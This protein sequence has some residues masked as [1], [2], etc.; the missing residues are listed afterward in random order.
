M[1]DRN[2][3]ETLRYLGYGRND[4][5]RQ[6]LTMAGECWSELERTAAKR[7]CFREYPLKFLDDGIMDLG[8]FQ[9]ES[10]SLS[11]NLKDCQ[12]VILFAATLGV[13][14]DSLIRKYSRLQMSRAVVLQAAAAAM[15]E[16]YCDQV[17]EQLR[18]DY[19]KK[20][21]YLRPRFSPGY[22]DFPLECQPAL[23]GGLEAGKRIGITLTDSLLMAPSKSVTAVIGVSPVERRCGVKGCE[24]CGKPDCIYRRDESRGILQKGIKRV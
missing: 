7:S 22:G 24:S 17:N 6:T 14:A 19:E 3:K 8:C 20:G 10:R 1:D 23:L 2:I 18:Q 15:L 4:P 21:L 12:A 11:K 16:D 5:D 13:Q 9:T